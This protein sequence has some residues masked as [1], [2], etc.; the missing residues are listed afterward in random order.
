MKPKSQPQ[1]MSK[2]KPSTTWNPQV[3]GEKELG[4]A[5]RKRSEA[6][7]MSEVETLQA[8]ID[9]LNAALAGP[10]ATEAQRKQLEQA[11]AK[12]YAAQY[13]AGLDQ[14]AT[15]GAK[16]ADQLRQAQDE[17][18]EAARRAKIEG[19]A[20]GMDLAMAALS[21]LNEQ[22]G[23]GDARS[24]SAMYKEAE[25]GLRGEA[26]Q[27]EEA[28]LLNI[29]E[30]EKRTVSDIQTA[31][32]DAAAKA[33]EAAAAKAEMGVPY[34]LKAQE[35]ADLNNYVE[36]VWSKYD[37]NIFDVDEKAAAQEVRNYAKDVYGPGTPEYDFLMLKAAELEGRD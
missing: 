20:A 16:E 35:K 11:E 33:V 26:A 5:L 32:E 31:E 17:W 14:Y 19:D 27:R 22:S 28:M 29:A 4:A 13:K 15:A 36:G 2:S 12:L 3:E 7:K 30:Q 1:H 9:S 25:R 37:A 18:A 23:R 21:R 6:A 10:G 8:E 24:A 34:K